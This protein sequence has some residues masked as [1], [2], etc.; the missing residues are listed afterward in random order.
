MMFFVE[1]YRRA[2]GKVLL[3]IPAGK[4][5]K[6]EEPYNC[7][8]RE[9]LEETNFIPGKMEYI[10]K[11]YTSPGFCNEIIYL[12]LAKNVEK[13]SCKKTLQEDEFINIKRINIKEALR[14]VQKGEIVDCKTIIGLLTVGSLLKNNEAGW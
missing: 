1:Q 10:T 11:F 7:A 8:E 2:V 6:G 12:Y 9:L 13:A 3:E 5:E 4:L 14:K